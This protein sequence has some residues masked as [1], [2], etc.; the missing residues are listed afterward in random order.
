[1]YARIAAA[2]V[3]ALDSRCLRSSESQDAAESSTMLKEV[4]SQP[5]GIIT[6]YAFCAR[7]DDLAANSTL[8]LCLP[9]ESSA[10]QERICEFAGLHVRRRFLHRAL[11]AQSARSNT[12]AIRDFIASMIASHKRFRQESVPWETAQVCVAL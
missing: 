11:P 12:D 6:T 1:M 2:S 5:R 10:S 8:R 7:A 3:Q 9:G 4:F